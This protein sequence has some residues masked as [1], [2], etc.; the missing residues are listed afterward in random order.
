MVKKDKKN[1]T[2]KDIA[3]LA[4]TS[5]ATVSNALSGERYVKAETRDK[6]LKLVKEHNY[7]PNIFARSLTRKETGI[8]AVITP[9][10][11]NSF[12]AEMISGIEEVARENDYVLM[13]SSTYYDDRSEYDNLR[14]LSRYNVDGFVL[15]GGTSTMDLRDTVVYKRPSVLVNR[16][17]DDKKKFPQI[18]I[19]YASLLRK[20]ISHL[21]ELGH[22][23][24][25]YMG[26]VS[27]RASISKI[28]Y[29]GLLEG[30][31][32]NGLD[33]DPN[34]YIKKNIILNE[35]TEAVEMVNANIDEIRKKKI[36]A[37]IAQTDMM[38]LGI[39]K[40][41]KDLG[42]RIPEDMSVLGIGNI[43]TSRYSNPPLSTV[44]IPKKRIGKLAADTLVS[45]LKNK[46]RKNETIYLSASIID[47]GSI[48]KV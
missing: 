31:A 48:K 25:A 38:A 11:N 6:I 5:P 14:I 13:L 26:W 10:I 2:I 15:L 35:Y 19:D 39:L 44:N 8:I 27:D 33:K 32:E 20:S 17:V 7:V 36:T 43:E 1:I 47:R 24:I 3:R 28:K 34:V 12:Y 16:D 30:L 18:C 46:S 4:G 40:A 23:K 9:D 22:K 37:I 21:I 42:M 29:T 45:K 41:L